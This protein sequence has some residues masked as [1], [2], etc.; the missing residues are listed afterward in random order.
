M[1][2]LMEQQLEWE[3]LQSLKKKKKTQSIQFF[4]PAVLMEQDC[5]R[6]T[7][8]TVPVARR[9]SSELIVTD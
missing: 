2:T 9:N 4:M 6:T 3:E 7:G 8:C 5:R 1:A